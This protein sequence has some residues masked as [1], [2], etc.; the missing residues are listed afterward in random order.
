[1]LS[2]ILINVCIQLHTLIAIP[3]NIC[4]Q[5]HILT[6]YLANMRSC[7]CINKFISIVYTQ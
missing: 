4:I 3:I 7:V 5:L 1:M 6:I 2:V